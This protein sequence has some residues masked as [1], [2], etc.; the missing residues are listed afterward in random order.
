MGTQ[1]GDAMISFCVE[2]WSCDNA[3][4]ESKFCIHHSDPPP[5]S[6]NQDE[7]RMNQDEIRT[8]PGWNE[9]RCCFCFCCCC[10]S[11]FCFCPCFYYRFRGSSD[12][13]SSRSNSS[14]SRSSSSSI[15]VHFILVSSWLH[16]DSS[17]FHPGFSLRRGSLCIHSIFERFSSSGKNEYASST[18]CN[19]IL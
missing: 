6:W 16:P 10:W 15:C 3:L 13:G 7:I 18:R 2:H 8:K 5:L 12:D 19:W 17:W 14:S 4:E 1:N 11:C 9:H